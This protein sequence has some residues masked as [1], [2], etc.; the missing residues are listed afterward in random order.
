MDSISGVIASTTTFS[1]TDGP[2]GVAA[3]Q[4][5][6]IL[7]NNTTYLMSIILLDETKSPVDTISN[8]VLD[9]GDVHL[10]VF[11]SNPSGQLVSTITDLDSNLKPIGLSSILSTSAT[12]VGTYSV[13]LRHFTSAQAKADNLVYD[14]DISILFNVRLQ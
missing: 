4:D 3:T 2:G 12:G 10:F 11:N 8:E 6:I 7:N 1:D 13:E 5:S 14:T 9:E